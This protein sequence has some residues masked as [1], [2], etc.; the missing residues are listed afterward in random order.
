MSTRANILFTDEYGDKQW[1]Y[2]HSDGYPEVT[3]KSL[4]TFVRWVVSGKI[5]DNISQGSGWLIILG[6][7]E[8]AKDDMCGL[9]P[10][11]EGYSGW[12]VGA[13]EPT[14]DQHG[15]IEWLYTV[16]LKEKTVTVKGLY[17]ELQNKYTFEEF[18]DH[19]F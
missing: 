15:D 14:T 5:R 9:E 4:Q 2:R 7:R 8:Y 18:L 10:R 1:Y 12:K 13:Y 16:D 3:A 19:E 17:E 6:N 11:S